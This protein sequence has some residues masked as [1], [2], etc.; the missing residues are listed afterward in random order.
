MTFVQKSYSSLSFY[1]HLLPQY[2]LCSKLTKSLMSPDIGASV[3][4]Q[5]TSFTVTEGVN[6]SVSICACAEMYRTTIVVDCPVVFE[7]EINLVVGE[8]AFYNH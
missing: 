6:M 7:F 8:G 1:L 4:L 3:R 5:Q 2:C